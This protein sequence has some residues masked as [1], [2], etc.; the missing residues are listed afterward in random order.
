MRSNMKNLYLY[1]VNTEMLTCPNSVQSV[2]ENQY[3]SYTINC[4]IPSAKVKDF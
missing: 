2:I 1:N 3:F 4:V